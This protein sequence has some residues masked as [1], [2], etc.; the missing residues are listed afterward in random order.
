VIDLT[1]PRRAVARLLACSCVLWLV[2]PLS[3][4]AAQRAASRRFEPSAD[5]DY[6]RCAYNIVPVLHGLTVVRGAQ[7]TPVA[8]MGFLWT[9]DISDAFD[10]PARAAAQR[11]VR[12]R[13]VAAV[14][15]DLGLLLA[16]SGLAVGIADDFDEN[17]AALL[18]GGAASLAI[19]VPLQFRADKFLAQATWLHNARYA[20]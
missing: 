18:A 5:C 2:M 4:A 19:S 6:Q 9:G 15:T 7:E 20:R 3:P 8:T 1:L 12:T 14:F 13:R 11:A 10:A 16:A 17:A